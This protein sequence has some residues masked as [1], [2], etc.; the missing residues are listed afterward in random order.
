[1]SAG[2]YGIL[3]E[4]KAAGPAILQDFH[5]IITSIWEDEDMPQDLCGASIVSLHKNKV[6]KITVAT[7]EAYHSYPL[8]GSFIAYIVLN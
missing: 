3:A 8:V 6:V 5:D 2:K 4:L 1:M 7:T